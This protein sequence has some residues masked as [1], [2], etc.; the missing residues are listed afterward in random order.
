MQHAERV[1]AIRPN[2]N[3]CILARLDFA[4]FLGGVR[5]GLH[6]VPVDFEDDVAFSQSCIVGRASGL[7][8]SNHGSANVLWSL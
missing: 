1:A 3:K 7:N 4:Q 6:G 2:Q 5:C 8:V